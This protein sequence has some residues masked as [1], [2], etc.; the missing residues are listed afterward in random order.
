[1]SRSSTS[2]P[3]RAALSR[4]AR[5]DEATAAPSPSRWKNAPVQY[6]VQARAIVETDERFFT[7]AGRGRRLRRPTAATGAAPARSSS[8]QRRPVFQEQTR[9][10]PLVGSITGHIAEQ[11]RARRPAADGAE[12]V[13]VPS[14]SATHLPESARSCARVSAS[15]SSSGRCGRAAL[16]LSRNT[17]PGAMPRSRGAFCSRIACHGVRLRARS[18]TRQAC[19]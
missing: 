5:E 10:P 16:A 19:S 15:I 4:T 18:T 9:R 13:Q 6:L 2:A 12:E 17:A 3:G 1:M 14:T 11:G 7:R 8:G